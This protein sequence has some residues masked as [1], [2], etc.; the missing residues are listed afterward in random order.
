MSDDPQGRPMIV[1]Y[2][3][4]SGVMVHIAP[5]STFTIV[6]IRER[7]EELFPYPDPAPYELPIENAVEGVK[8]PASQ[9]P[10][11]QE[12]CKPID[13]ERLAY[14]MKAYIDIA[15][16]FPAFETPDALIGHFRPRLEQLRKVSK[17]DNDDWQNVL[18]HCVFTGRKDRETV[19]SIAVQNETIPL[20]PAEVVEGVRFFRAQIPGQTA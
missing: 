15:C 20:T 11:Y 18:N 13:A 8:A 19:L 12:L 6:A 1:Q 16:T 9:N 14:R 5:L 17:L 2:E 4:A 10:E 7:S 3:P